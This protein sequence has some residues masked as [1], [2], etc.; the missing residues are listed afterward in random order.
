MASPELVSSAEPGLGRELQRWAAASGIDCCTPEH[1]EY[2]T[3][4]LVYNRIHDAY[5]VAVVSP[6]SAAEVAQCLRFARAQALPLAVR[7]GGHHVGGFGTCDAGLV[8]DL[9]SMRRVAIGNEGVASVGA[10]ARLGHVDGFLCPRGFVVPTGTVSDTGIAGL[11]LGG[12]IG[13]L[14]G[15]YGLT[16]DNLVGADVV[17]GDGEL[18]RAEAPEH[19]ELLWALRGGGGGLGIVTEFRFRTHRLPICV[20]GSLVVQAAGARAALW[21][22]V[23]FLEERCPARL[24]VAPVLRQDSDGRLALFVDFCLAGSD[25][26]ALDRLI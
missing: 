22:L 4:R 26:R 11:A 23:Q 12:G 15:L 24:T 14:L 5:P 18:V 9:G 1:P 13:W 8:I 21:R 10:G 25:E 19:G 7:G 2:A 17:V 20:A 16:C 3:K 6:R